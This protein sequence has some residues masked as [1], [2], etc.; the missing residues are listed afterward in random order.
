MSQVIKPSTGSGPIGPYIQQING[1]VGYIQGATVTIYAD[2]AANNSG[3]SVE[4]VNSGT[5]STLNLTDAHG[6]TMLGSGSGN[7]SLTVGTAINNTGVGAATFN[8]VTTGSD[9]TALGF[10]ALIMATTATENTAVGNQALQ[11]NSTAAD[12]TAVGSQS[13]KKAT[14]N[15]NTTVGQA[16]GENYTTGTNNTFI[17][18]NAGSTYTSSES[19]N[20]IIGANVTGTLGESNVIR[21]GS[22]SGTATFVD[23]ITG[24]TVAG[25]A[26]IGVA[27]TGRLSSLGFGT[28]GQV[29]TSNGASTSPTWQAASAHALVSL[30]PDFNNTAGFGASGAIT[31]TSGNVNVKGI[32][33]GTSATQV[34][35]TLNSSS[36]ATGTIQVEDRTFV[37][38]YVVDA[39][40]TGGAR[41][42]YTTIA[43]ALAAAVTDGASISVVKNIYIRPGLYTENNTIS[44]GINLVGLVDQE[45][46]GGTPAVTIVGTLTF[47]GTGSYAISNINLQT[48]SAPII[49]VTGTNA[50]LVHVTNCNMVISNNT[51]ISCSNANATINYIN[52][53]SQITTTGISLF[54]MTGGNLTW[55][56]SDCGNPGLSTT[57]S[58]ATTGIIAFNYCFI[59][60]PITTSS[61]ASM[62][63]NWSTFDTSAQN[64]TPLTIGGSGTNDLNYCNIAAGSASAVSIG[65]GATCGTYEC[66]INST[67][68]NAIT[69]AGTIEFGGLLFVNSS[70]LINTTTQAAN[71]FIPGAQQTVSPAGSYTVL[72]SDMI[73]AASSSAPH[74]ITLPASPSNGEVHIIKD[75]TGT[76]AANNITVS[77]NGNN[78]DGAASKLIATNYGSMRVAFIGTVWFTI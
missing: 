68:T 14:G 73:I 64:V 36:S 13:S 44:P 6:N 75:I 17:G 38:P 4:F 21:I 71:V 49:S 69:G 46:S 52:C 58:T 55:D 42:T 56:N 29:L 2:Q 31:G 5:I 1:D 19:N 30:T 60:I 25:T 63:N 33:V 43:L 51:A 27:S 9:N 24:V 50:V 41:G 32:T 16:S 34:T 57:A 72:A 65:M 28:S 77:G 67:N 78:I 47:T 10:H 61:T 74:T 20:I 15:Q 18:Y 59:D 11:N 23:G 37:T 39:S 12:N 26:P 3:Y 53:T 7:L 45:A 22:G 70:S 66:N 76:A 35:D 54:A 8:H 62:I 40:I 48:N